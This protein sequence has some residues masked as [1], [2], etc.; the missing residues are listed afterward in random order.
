[1]Q[2]SE[3]VGKQSIHIDEM[4]TDK[5]QPAGQRGR[6]RRFPSTRSKVNEDYWA[7]YIFLRPPPTSTMSSSGAGTWPALSTTVTPASRTLPSTQWVLSN[8]RRM[9]P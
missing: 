9:E 7:P 2:F 6:S 5:P 3:L 4:A 8:Y 1:M